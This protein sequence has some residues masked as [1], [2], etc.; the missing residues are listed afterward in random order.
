MS[1]EQAGYQAENWHNVVNRLTG[2]RQKVYRAFEKFGP[3]TTMELTGRSGISPFIVRPR[4]TELLQIGLV[5]RVA[6][7]KTAHKAEGVF[8][9]V[10]LKK[11][12]ERAQT[13]TKP[14]QLALL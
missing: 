6:T 10:D 2:W 8:S 1:E 5:E 14:E 12:I 9:A 4:T 7:R 13:R 11:A 3:C